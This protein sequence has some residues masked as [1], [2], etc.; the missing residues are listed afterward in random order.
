MFSRE[1]R[2]MEGWAEEGGGAQSSENTRRVYDSCHGNSNCN[3]AVQE[4]CNSDSGRGGSY[5]PQHI[6]SGIDIDT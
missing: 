1:D 3:L 6:H 2:G 4:H 5:V